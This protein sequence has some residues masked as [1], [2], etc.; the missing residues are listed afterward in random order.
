MKLSAQSGCDQVT[1]EFRIPVLRELFSYIWGPLHL[2]QQRTV[3]I[4]KQRN[5]GV[6]TSTYENLSD[7]FV[8]YK[9]YYATYEVHAGLLIQVPFKISRCVKVPRCSCNIQ[10]KQNRK[11]GPGS[12]AWSYRNTRMRN[13]MRIKWLVLPGMIGWLRP[14]SD[15]THT[16]IHLVHTNTKSLKQAGTCS[17]IQVKELTW[18]KGTELGAAFKNILKGAATVNPSS[19]G[20]TCT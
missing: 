15:S 9:Y 7:L 6:C 2:R 20:A 1:D 14:Y 13:K 18:I 11:Q 10:Q 8:H 3:T 5:I 16:L 19:P 12:R 4:Q 17:E